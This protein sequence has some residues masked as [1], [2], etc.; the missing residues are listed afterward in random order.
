MRDLGLRGVKFHPTA[1]AFYPND[2]RFYPM[3]EKC[4]ELGVPVLI[5]TGVTGFG[6]GAPGGGGLKTKYCAPIPYI[7][8]LAADFPQLTVIM[9]HPGFPWVE[10][11]MAV[12]LHKPNVHMDLSG[13][14]PRYF[15]PPI[16]TYGNSLLQ[17][18]MMFGSDYPSLRPDRWLT[19]FAEAPF[20]EE[21][22]DKILIENARR[23]LGLEV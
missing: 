13:Y 15:Q 19:D 8:D 9:A 22:R 20:R 10:E 11:Q 23:I 14:S 6:A 3:W 7:D 5:H 18:R 21:V 12:L 2:V 1:Q 4:A 16:L 17:D